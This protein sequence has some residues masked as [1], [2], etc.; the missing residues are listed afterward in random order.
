MRTVPNLRDARTRF[1]WPIY[2][3]PLSKEILMENGCLSL[4]PFLFDKIRFIRLVIIEGHPLSMT[5][6]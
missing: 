5:C 2:F 3:L 6:S 1:Y 4:S